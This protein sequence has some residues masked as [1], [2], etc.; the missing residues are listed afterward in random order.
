MS[1]FNRQKFFS[2]GT[3]IRVIIWLFTMMVA[4]I[5][6]SAY[7]FLDVLDD[8][9]QA[10]IDKRVEI[11]FINES[12]HQQDIVEGFTYSDEAYQKLFIDNSDQWHSTNTGDFLIKNKFFDFSLVVD[13][14]RKR[15]LTQSRDTVSLDLEDLMQAGMAQLMTGSW[16]EMSLTKTHSSFM[17]LNDGVYLVSGSPFVSENTNKPRMGTF[18]AIGKRLDKD[19]VFE[20]AHSYQIFDLSLSLKPNPQANKVLFSDAGEKIAWLSWNAVVPTKLVFPQVATVTVSCALLSILVTWLIISRASQDREAYES[21][22]YKAATRDGLTDVYNHRHFVE[23]A[24]HEYK[25]SRYLGKPLCLLV[26]DIDYFKTINDT[27]GHQ[28]GDDAL[29]HFVSLCSHKLR[30]SDLLGRIGGE[31]FALLMPDTSLKKAIEFAESLRELIKFSP[32]VTKKAKI[33]FT[34]SIGVSATVIDG[35]FESMLE[36]ADQAM[37]RAK[38][39]GRNQVQICD[40]SIEPK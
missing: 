22:L 31:E 34:V 7:F 30:S 8:K 16:S 35:D 26:M 28:T 11:T 24:S 12:R 21:K 40:Q 36:R 23:A 39:L 2:T 14:R 25:V 6:C 33:S 4:A 17:L 19:Y 10:L 15:F 32:L 38:H 29:K 5:L 13:N 1:A 27:Y 9:A 18:L 3:L 20:L 37:Y